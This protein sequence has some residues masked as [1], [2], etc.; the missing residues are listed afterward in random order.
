MDITECQEK[1]LHL[2]INNHEIVNKFHAT[3]IDT[4]CFDPKY[5]PLLYGIYEAHRKDIRLT[6][7]GYLDFIERAVAN[8]E[9][10]R[11]IESKSAGANQSILK[12][13]KLFVQLGNF[14]RV[15]K[16]DFELLVT[17]LKE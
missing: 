11:W 13:R 16:N 17:K 7:A 2:L 3:G 5:R 6:E 1:I 4:E 9:Y 12:E 14:R 15:D 10:E 8:K